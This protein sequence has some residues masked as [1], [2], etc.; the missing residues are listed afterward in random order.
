MEACTTLDCGA[1]VSHMLG[2]RG[3][4][5]ALLVKTSETAF[6]CVVGEHFIGRM[7]LVMMIN[8]WGCVRYGWLHN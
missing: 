6:K 1:M 3:N 7:K 4:H 8:S 2:P 5:S